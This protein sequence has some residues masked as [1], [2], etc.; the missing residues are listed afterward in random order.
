MKND[1]LQATVG[2]SQAFARGLK[3]IY[4]QDRTRVH[5]RHHRMTRYRG[6]LLSL[7]SLD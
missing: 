6:K 4:V 3:E 1:L 7:F 5:P 2:Y